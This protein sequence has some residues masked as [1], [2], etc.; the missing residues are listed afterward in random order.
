MRLLLACGGSGG[1]ISPAIAV[2]DK[3]SEEGGEVLFLGSRKE[4][5]NEF[6]Q[7][8][9]YKFKALSSAP[10]P[11]KFSTDLFKSIYNN[12]RAI[13]QARSVLKEFKPDVVL[14]TGSYASG[15]PVIAAFWLGIPVAIHEQNSYPGLTNRLLAR[16]ADRVAISYPRSEQYFTKAAGNKIHYTG[17]PVRSEIIALDRRE[18]RQKFDVPADSFVIIVMGGSQGAE[19]INKSMFLTYDKILDNNYY[20]FHITGK[21]HY[22]EILARAKRELTNEQRDRITFFAFCEEIEYLF[23]A[24]DLFIGR[25][26]ATTLAEITVCGLPAILI[27]YPHAVADHQEYNA[28]ELAKAGA[29]EII[30]EK[31][32]NS[33]GLVRAIEKL[34]KNDKFREMSEASLSLGKPGATE[35]L[36]SILK[37]LAEGEK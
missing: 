35:N 6:L 23:S 1:H 26:G 27:P 21:D 5:E 3:C 2:A 17:N 28:R 30:K 29:A 33:D 10:L 7:N 18:A 12:F 19:N 36:M 9:N 15:A 11:R 14:G 22:E 20:I 13:F 34:H 8:Q 37:V 25:A 32:L 16:K 4:L 31:N 24:A